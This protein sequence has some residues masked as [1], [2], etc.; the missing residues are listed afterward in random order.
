MEAIFVMV[1]LFLIGTVAMFYV[2]FSDRKQRHQ[3]T[4][5]N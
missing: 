3:L 2:E 4:I 1:G 5:N